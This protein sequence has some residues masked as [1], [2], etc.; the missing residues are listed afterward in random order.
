MNN[1]PIHTIL[2]IGKEVLSLRFSASVSELDGSFEAAIA[3][4]GSDFDPF[5]KGTEELSI[6]MV[7]GLTKEHSW[8]GGE[9]NNIKLAL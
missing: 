1:S 3:Y 5:T 6:K 9:G 8:S 7:L 2:S 4:G